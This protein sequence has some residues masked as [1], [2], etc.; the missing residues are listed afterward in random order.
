MD[1]MENIDLE[2]GLDLD[3]GM[4]KKGK[5]PPAM[6][7]RLLTQDHID[8]ALIKDIVAAA[9]GCGFNLSVGDCMNIVQ[10]CVKNHRYEHAW[11]Y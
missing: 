1:P 7:R 6:P 3:E 4:D 10:V 2:I 11:Q 8:A 5:L 9:A